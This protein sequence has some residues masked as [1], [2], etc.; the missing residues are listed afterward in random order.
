MTPENKT[1][2]LLSICSPKSIA[3]FGASNRFTSMGTNMLAS[4]QKSGFAGP[5][6]PV[7]PKEDTV[8]GLKAYR[9]VLDLPE[10]PDLAVM[11][12][13]A[14]IVPRAMEAC[15]RKGIKGA[16]VVSGGFAEAGRRRQ[17]RQDRL[18]E[19]ARQYGMRFVGPNCLGVVN[20]HHD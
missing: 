15:G 3:W 12:L 1:D 13:P 2:P 8:L 17:E 11:V 14:G 20:T 16:I 4:L 9:N 18:K 7:H 6:Y 19:I 5:V 10:V